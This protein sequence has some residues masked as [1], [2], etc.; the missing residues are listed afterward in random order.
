L[1]FDAPNRVLLRAD[2]AGPWKLIILPVYDI[3][4]GFPYSVENQY[5]QYLGPRD[6]LRYPRFSSFDLQVS[7]PLSIPAGE[8]HIKATAGIGVFN[9]FNH[10]NPRDVQNDIN[11][12]QFGNFYNDA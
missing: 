4:T 1:P 12:A 10:F 8:R 5:R 11:S 9:L 2:I 6:A 7:R 3:H